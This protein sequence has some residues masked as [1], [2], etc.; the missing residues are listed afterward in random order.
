MKNKF[1]LE[2]WAQHLYVCVI[3]VS[4]VCLMAHKKV[5]RVQITFTAEQW[6]ILRRLKGIM[7]NDDAEVIRNVVLSW[8]S[9]KSIIA[10]AIKE[11]LRETS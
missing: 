8:L 1:I 3:H 6:N 5:K 9:E 10:S 11:I 2:E 7:G 4:L